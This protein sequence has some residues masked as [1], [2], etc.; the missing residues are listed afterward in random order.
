LVLLIDLVT[1][2]RCTQISRKPLLFHLRQGLNNIIVELMNR[3]LCFNNIKGLKLH[4]RDKFF[5]D[6]FCM[7][8]G[9]H[10]FAQCLSLARFPFGHTTHQQPPP[11][12]THSHILGGVDF[13]CHNAT[14]TL[15][16]TLCKREGRRS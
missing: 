6:I 3:I 15:T 11:T 9:H 14:C 7:L 16:L 12:L 4:F 5:L 13:F 2:K 10:C 8:S 1:L